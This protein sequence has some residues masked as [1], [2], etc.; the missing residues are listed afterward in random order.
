MTVCAYKFEVAAF[1]YISSNDCGVKVGHGPAPAF[2]ATGPCERHFN[3]STC[4]DLQIA[5]FSENLFCGFS[6]SFPNII[7]VEIPAPPR[8]VVA[9]AATHWLCRIASGLIQVSRVLECRCWPLLADNGRFMSRSISGIFSH[10]PRYFTIVLRISLR[11]WQS[12][13]M[14]KIPYARFSYKNLN[15]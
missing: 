4:E 11:A 7:D 12:Q 13:K 15:E 2:T 6:R 1:E 10:P 14:R 8:V 5:R 9:I 3:Q